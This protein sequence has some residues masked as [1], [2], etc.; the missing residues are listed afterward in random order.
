MFFRKW[1]VT[2]NLATLCTYTKCLLN[3]GNIMNHYLL[4]DEKETD[5]NTFH[6][7]ILED[8]SNITCSFIRYHCMNM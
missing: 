6:N 7:N 4:R 8:Y 1:G 2:S 5:C 3:H